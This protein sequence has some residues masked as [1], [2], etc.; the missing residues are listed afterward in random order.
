[1]ITWL[2]VCLSI[3]IESLNQFSQ[4]CHW[5]KDFKDVKLTEKPNR[6]S[7][8]PVLVFRCIL[9]SC[10]SAPFVFKKQRLKIKKK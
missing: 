3:N 1:M 10:V 8:G 9:Q 2:S 4:I 5:Q 6:V 7:S